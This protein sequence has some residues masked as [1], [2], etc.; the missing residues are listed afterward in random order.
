MNYLTY[1]RNSPPPVQADVQ[2]ELDDRCR[3]N[4]LSQEEAAINLYTAE[5]PALYK[6]LNRGLND[7]DPEILQ[8]HG[9][10][11]NKILLAI[12]NRCRN[13]YA[14]LDP[15]VWGG[16]ILEIGSKKR[17]FVNRGFV[18]RGMKL[19]RRLWG[20]YYMGRRFIWPAFVST[21]PDWEVAKRFCKN[22]DGSFPPEAIIFKITFTSG[23]TYAYDIT[24]FSDFPDEQEILI[25]PGSGF[26][27]VQEPWYDRQT[28]LMYGE[29]RTIGTWTA[30]HS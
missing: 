19:E 27:V 6:E 13:R 23:C 24:R 9:G 14:H 17:R 15:R 11:I 21:T 2:R 3:V 22:D 28:G 29:L 20:E 4:S 7:D 8:S 18:Y 30:E 16:W 5:Y 12:R 25:Y 1:C 26:E 10:L